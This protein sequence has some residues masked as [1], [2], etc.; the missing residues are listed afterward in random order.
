MDQTLLLLPQ[1]RRGRW[2]FPPAPQARCSS[3]YRVPDRTAGREHHRAAASAHTGTGAHV[4]P[5]V[6]SIYTGVRGDET[7]CSP[8][9][10]TGASACAG[11]HGRAKT[12]T[13]AFR[14]RSSRR[15]RRPVT[16]SPR[17]YCGGSICRR[18]CATPLGYY[19]EVWPRSAAIA[20]SNM[21]VRRGAQYYRHLASGS[22]W[23]PTPK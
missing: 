9:L 4:Q 18:P 22:S 1:G 19:L 5:G 20:R 17:D 14:H 7:R 8:C 21:T 6:N 23:R 2:P 3:G 15:A 12:V 10:P 16:I 11:S 13:N